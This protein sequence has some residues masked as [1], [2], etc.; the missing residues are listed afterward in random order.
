MVKMKPIALLIA[1][2]LTAG[3]IA[4]FFLPAVSAGKYNSK[5]NLGDRAPDFQNLPGTDGK[6]HSLTDYVDKDIV[7]LVFLTNHCPVS[8]GYEERLISFAKKLAGDGKTAL[9]AINVNTLEDD[10]LPK[11][12]ERAKERG[13]NFPYLYD[14]TQN[15]GRKLGASVT[16]EFFVLDKQRKIVYMGA[17]D[18]NDDAERASVNYLEPALRAV[19]KGERPE[20]AETRPRGCSIFYDK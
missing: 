10:K 15:L 6:K 12:I 7:V 3:G 8:K 17:M 11:M 16:P 9:L 2:L 20:V 18:N 14:E 13:F 19:L 5:V 4:T 1:C